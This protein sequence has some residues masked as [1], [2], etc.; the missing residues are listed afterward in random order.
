[1]MCARSSTVIVRVVLSRVMGEKLTRRGCRPR[2]GT[3]P[4]VSSALPGER[5]EAG[6]DQRAQ[7]QRRQHQ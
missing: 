1:M 6:R 2:A 5:H 3:E 7:Q 4:E